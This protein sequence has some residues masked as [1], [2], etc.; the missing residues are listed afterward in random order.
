MD[1][2]LL[3]IKIFL[4][5]VLEKLNSIE[6]TEYVENQRNVWNGFLI[7]INLPFRVVSY[8]G[9]QLAARKVSFR[10]QHWQVGKVLGKILQESYFTCYKSIFYNNILEQ[11]CSNLRL[12]DD[13]NG[14]ML[15]VVS[16]TISF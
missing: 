15:V 12:V 10:G 16:S 6:D 5:K 13:Q 2:N 4:E 9:L 11:V 7:S 1:S 8:N 14:P 3:A